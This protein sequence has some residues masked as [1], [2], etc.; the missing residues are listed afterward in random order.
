MDGEGPFANYKMKF[1][2]VEKECLNK[3]ELERLE[4]KTFAVERLD[5]VRDLFVFSC[6]TGLA[7]VDVANLTADHIVT[8]NDNEKAGSNSTGRKPPHWCSSLCY[9]RLLKLSRNIKTTFAPM[10]WSAC[11]LY[12]QIK[13]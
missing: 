10:Q 4:K 9:R 6:Y 7:Y 11:F 5:F 12:C 8:G 2:K 13:R 3:H 1:D